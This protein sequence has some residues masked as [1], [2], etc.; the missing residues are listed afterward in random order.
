MP[1]SDDPKDQE[2]ST[3][4]LRVISEAEADG[5]LQLKQRE[6]KLDQRELELKEEIKRRDQDPE[7]IKLNHQ[8]NIEKFKLRTKT[9]VSLVILIVGIIFHV[10][11]DNI[12]A[13]L[14][15]SG[16]GGFGITMASSPSTSKTEQE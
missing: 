5:L 1:P 3:P 11:D 15:G 4:N 12:G 14:I 16:L 2:S 13:F 9:A 8:L 6:Q 7:L 10:T